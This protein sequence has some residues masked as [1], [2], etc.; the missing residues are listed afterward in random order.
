MSFPAVLAALAGRLDP[1]H[2]LGRG[3][4]N[5]LKTKLICFI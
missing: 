4:F 1:L 3:Y 5:P 2:E